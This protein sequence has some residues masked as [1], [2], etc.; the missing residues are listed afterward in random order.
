MELFV[1]QHLLYVDGKNC[2]RYVINDI[3]HD[4][5]NEHY[6]FEYV[7]RDGIEVKR[8]HVLVDK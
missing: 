5:D 4:F 2:K 1:I 6:L 7:S 3:E 8:N